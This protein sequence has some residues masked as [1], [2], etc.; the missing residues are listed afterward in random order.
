MLVCCSILSLQIIYI[1][2]M[3]ASA[4]N[5][6]IFKSMKLEQF[7]CFFLDFCLWSQDD[8][9]WSGCHFLPH[10]YS[11]VLPSASEALRGS[12]GTELEK[13]LCFILS[14]GVEKWILHW[15][16]KRRER[17][18]RMLC[19]ACATHGFCHLLLKSVWGGVCLFSCRLIYQLPAIRM[20]SDCHWRASPLTRTLTLVLLSLLNCSLKPDISSFCWL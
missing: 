19:L 8:W 9:W 1:L 18:Q 11:G 6:C 4:P 5:Q 15:S 7:D 13:V 2:G 17:S 10:I 20:K 16:E 14:D 3:E 12:A